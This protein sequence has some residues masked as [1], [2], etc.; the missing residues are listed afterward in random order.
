MDIL[1]L[2]P[3][4]VGDTDDTYEVEG[5]EDHIEDIENQFPEED[6][7][8]PEEIAEAQALEEQTTPEESIQPTAVETQNPLP[9]PQEETGFQPKATTS[10]FT[11][12]E[13]GMISNEQLMQAYGGKIPPE[14]VIRGLKLN[15]SYD[16]EKEGILT[17][18]PFTIIDL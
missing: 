5:Y 7:R 18:A 15:Y 11:P 1:K 13:N 16:A 14:G 10:F 2:N 4:D 9:Q 8:T 12:D 3:N 6:F 17:T